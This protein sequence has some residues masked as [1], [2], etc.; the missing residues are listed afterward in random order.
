MSEK[1][2]KKIYILQEV[3]DDITHYIAN[4][5]PER[6]GLLLGPPHKDAVTIFL[7]DEWGSR[8][9]ST[10]TPAAEKLSEMAQEINSREGWI[11]KGVVHSH[12]GGMGSLSFGDIEAIN[13]YFEINPGMPYFIGLIVYNDKTEDEAQKGNMFTPMKGNNCNAMVAHVVHSDESNKEEVQK[14]LIPIDIFTDLSEVPTSLI[15]FESKKM[16]S[17]YLQNMNTRIL[18]ILIESELTK[19]LG[20]VTDFCYSPLQIE[21]NEINSFQFGFSHATQEWEVICLLPYEFPIIGPQICLSSLSG[22]DINFS[23]PWDIESKLT[24]G[25]QLCKK[26][27][28]E[29]EIRLST[30]EFS[31]NILSEVLEIQS[32][33]NAQHTVKDCLISVVEFD[34]SDL[35]LKIKCQIPNQFPLFPPRIILIPQNDNEYDLP[36]SWDSETKELPEHQVGRLIKEALFKP[37]KSL[38][39]VSDKS[40]ISYGP[41]GS[42]ILATTDKTLAKQQGWVPFYSQKRTPLNIEDEYFAR[43]GG[44]LSKKLREKCVVIFGCG[45][46]GSYL[47]E[48]LV[49]SGL[50]KL[51]LCDMDIVKAQNLCRSG[52]EITDLGVAKVDALAR[53]LR[54]INPSVQLTL[55]NQSLLD[56]PPKQLRELIERGQ[57]VI[58]GTDMPEAQDRLN[59]YCYKIGVPALFPALYEKAEGGQI[60]LTIPRKTPCHS[61]S[62]RLRD[63]LN[64]YYDNNNEEQSRSFESPNIGEFDYSTGT[65]IAEPGLVGDIQ[66]LDSITLKL[67]LGLLLQN[68]PD[69]EQC[70]TRDFLRGL[71][72]QNDD[73]SSTTKNYIIV[74]HSQTFWFFPDVRDNPKQDYAYHSV[75][76]DTHDVHQS[77]CPICGEHPE[78]IKDSPSMK[79]IVSVGKLLNV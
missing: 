43:S 66:H 40:V 53:K 9:G 33:S 41:V 49:R 15:P 74:S 28:K 70:E 37:M 51:V 25:E 50:G 19:W 59:N 79:D 67:V 4:H 34:L 35:D 46:G 16:E 38:Q 64:S 77:D 47:A 52:Y 58:A 18:S 22:E 21:G 60:I 6:G 14:R 45:S 61:C 62:L 73:G 36:V 20:S 12:P 48:Q 2:I 24:I 39:T 76:L 26:L 13:D 69:N 65:L 71:T 29:L 8:S 78:P 10:Y 75:W 57:V 54:N 55:K 63:L 72:T 31:Q 3:I 17:S 32:F 27:K 56:L 7:Y 30:P 42:T 23:L 1:R 5:P 11:I 68:I 44:I